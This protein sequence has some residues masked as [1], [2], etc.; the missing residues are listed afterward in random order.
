MSHQAVVKERIL[1]T[2]STLFSRFGFVKTTIEDIAHALM[3]SKGALYYYFKNKDDLFA[4]II[5]RECASFL[6]QIEAAIAS[7]SSFGDKLKAYASTRMQLFKNLANSYQTFMDD[8]LK[9]YSLIQRLRSRYDTF[10][11]ELIRSLLNQGVACSEFDIR[12][13]ALAAKA[14][15]ASVKGLEYE[16]AT[17]K[18]P[19]EIRNNSALLLDLLLHGILTHKRDTTPQAEFL[20]PE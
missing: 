20:G 5:E 9:H 3:M 15:F 18:T 8:Y 10:E 19:D 16:W 7:Y 4:E 14:I 1:T 2:S 6:E 17:S 11:I 13:T 12:D